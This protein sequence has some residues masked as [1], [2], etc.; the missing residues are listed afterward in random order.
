M[1]AKDT[2]S[3]AYAPVAPPAT[4]REAEQATM[5]AI[6]GIAEHVTSSER[7]TDASTV[8]ASPSTRPLRLLSVMYYWV[9]S[10]S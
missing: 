2:D 8:S 4:V 6:V 9:L 10:R 7:S 5:N 3:Q 1:N